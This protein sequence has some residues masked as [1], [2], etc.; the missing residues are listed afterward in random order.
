MLL[1]CTD[2]ELPSAKLTPGVVVCVS[3]THGA[4]HVQLSAT[5]LS[6]GSHAALRQSSAQLQTH[7]AVQ[8]LKNLSAAV[9]RLRSGTF[10]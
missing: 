5:R 2:V 7:Q 3:P 10:C 8:V 6:P 9:K 1:C 4:R